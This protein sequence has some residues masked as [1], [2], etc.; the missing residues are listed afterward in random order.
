MFGL[1]EGQEKLGKYLF[2]TIASASNQEDYAS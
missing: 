1:F 2:N